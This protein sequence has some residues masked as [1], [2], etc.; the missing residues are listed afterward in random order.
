LASEATRGLRAVIQ[1]YAAD[2]SELAFETEVVLLDLNQPQQYQEA[3][4][5]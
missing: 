1:R 2:V 4:A 3:C 5:S